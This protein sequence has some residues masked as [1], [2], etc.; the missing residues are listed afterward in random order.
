LALSLGLWGPALAQDDAF[1]FDVRAY[2]VQGNTALTPA[3]IEAALAPV[4]GPKQR[5]EDV[6]R[7]VDLLQAAY[8]QA[9]FATVR[10]ALPEQDVMNGVVRLVVTEP[11]LVALRAEEAPSGQPL[12]WTSQ[13]IQHLLPALRLGASPNIPAIDAAVRMANAK[14]ARVLAV[15][16][17]ATGRDNGV[18]AI[19]KVRQGRTR[20]NS[21]RLDNS[22][23]VSSGRSR[24]SWLWQDSQ[25]SPRDDALTLQAT[26]SP[27]R[28]KHTQSLA[29]FYQLPNYRQRLN[30]TLTAAWSNTNATPVATD[31][32]LL[33][34][35]GRSHLLGLRLSHVLKPHKTWEHQW[36]VA[37]EHRSYFNACSLGRY[38]E[39]GC[40]AGNVDYTL[41]PVTMGYAAQRQGP[42]WSASTQWGV[43]ANVPMGSRGSTATL[44]S[45]RAGA[46]ANY[47]VLR[48]QVEAQRQLRSADWRLHG[49]LRLQV[50]PYALTA[51]AQFTMGGAH[52]VRGY[53]S[54]AVTA[55]SG[56]QASLELRHSVKAPW[57]Q[58]LGEVQV[59]AFVD[60]GHSTR[61]HVLPGERRQRSLA[62]WGLG[63]RSQSRSGWR[64]EVDLA[65][66]QLASGTVS[67][68]DWR[69]HAAVT[70][71]W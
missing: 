36:F 64:T 59:L 33:R 7:A 8:Q 57:Q 38:G 2:E 40:L 52:S 35:S 16:L 19:V 39:T 41:H 32:G 58:R 61:R 26:T 63:W 20:G 66:A 55:D 53:P 42:Q 54:N 15:G 3:A 10:V 65:R 11:R 13:R 46:Q 27:A 28:P 25:L 60:A 6:L 1:R 49:A 68:G 48:G 62:S 34:F 17:A 71:T 29:T 69:A 9:G 67:R 31:V 56:G 45:T 18:E 21:V 30:W 22:G 24:L 4:R 5:F 50:S 70:K 47:V 14:P 37:L 51:P 44:Q 43:S 23:T 12:A